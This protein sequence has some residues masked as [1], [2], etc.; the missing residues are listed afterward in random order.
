MHRWTYPVQPVRSTSPAAAAAEPAAL[1][2]GYV[3]NINEEPLPG[4]QVRLD[5][6]NNTS[7]LTDLDGAFRFETKPG[8]HTLAVEAGCWG[9]ATFPIHVEDQV[10]LDLRLDV[11]APPPAAPENMHAAAPP[12][13]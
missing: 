1:V 10:A 11:L 5:A 9:S 6:P 8:D 4:V 12:G 2:E 13:P 7:T 3:W